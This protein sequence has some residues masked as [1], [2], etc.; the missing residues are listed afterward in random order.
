MKEPDSAARLTRGLKTGAR[1][2]L[3][4]QLNTAFGGK[5]GGAAR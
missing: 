1:R 4:G 5:R 3:Y 2:P